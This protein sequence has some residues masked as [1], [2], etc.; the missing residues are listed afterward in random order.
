MNAPLSIPLRLDTPLW[1]M[2]T[3]LDGVEYILQF[4]WNDRAQRWLFSLYS[5]TQAPLATGVTVLGGQYPLLNFPPIL[6]GLLAFVDNSSATPAPPLFA[7][8]GRRV[9]LY[10]WPM[11]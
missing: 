7:D 10:Y 4:D 6:P 3:T 5:L 11:T 8:L 1:R 2:R 9:K